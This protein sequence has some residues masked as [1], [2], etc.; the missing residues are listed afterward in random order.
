M[1]TGPDYELQQPTAYA[2]PDLPMASD[3]LIEAC[4]VL[5]DVA[6]GSRVLLL[7]LVDVLLERG[8]PRRLA[9]WTVWELAERGAFQ[10][11]PRLKIDLFSEKGGIS[12]VPMAL[13]SLHDFYVD[14]NGAMFRDDELIALDPSAPVQ[15]DEVE[16]EPVAEVLDKLAQALASQRPLPRTT[17]PR[18]KRSTVKRAGRPPKTS[19]D[20]SLYEEFS[21]WNGTL[22]AFA[23]SKKMKEPACRLAIKRGKEALKRRNKSKGR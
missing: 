16:A 2:R 18:K 11:H 15:W 9:Y 20:V 17:K 6:A 21:E 12:R 13:P 5:G 7:R 23:E 10:F 1:G 19:R 3:T 14:E 4:R 22:K 8:H